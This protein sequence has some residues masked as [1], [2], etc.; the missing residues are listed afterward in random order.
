FAYDAPVRVILR[1]TTDLDGD[2]SVVREVNLAVDHIAG[3]AVFNGEYEDLLVSGVR[4]DAELAYVLALHLSVRRILRAGRKEPHGIHVP[5][6][7]GAL[8]G[9]HLGPEYSDCDCCIECWEKKNDR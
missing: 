6:V 2:R 7:D 3:I 8:D 1:D 5:G 4:L 9:E